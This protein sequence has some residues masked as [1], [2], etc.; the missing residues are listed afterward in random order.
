[1]GQ[2]WAPKAVWRTG[3]QGK[4]MGCA[5]GAGVDEAVGWAGEGQDS[6]GSGE[7]AMARPEE[8]SLKISIK[9]NEPEDVGEALEA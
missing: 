7:M 8:S 2:D 3:A 4:C 1:L 9:Q 6:G 5:C